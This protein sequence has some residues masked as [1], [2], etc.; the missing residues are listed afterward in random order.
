MRHCDEIAALFGPTPQCVESR[1]SLN[2]GRWVFRISQCQVPEVARLE[3]LLHPHINSDETKLSLSVDN[4]APL[5]L[6]TSQ[7]DS[8]KEFV[9]DL[10]P[11]VAA[12]QPESILELTV[13]VSKNEQERRLSIY[14]LNAFIE[15]FC[16]LT[17]TQWLASLEQLCSANEGFILFLQQKSNK[18]FQTETLVFSAQKQPLPSLA[19]SDLLSSRKDT[20]HFDGAAMCFVPEDFHLLTRSSSAELNQVLDR[21]CLITT[22]AFL[23]DV[24]TFS[25]DGTLTFKLNGYRAITGTINASPVSP[26]LLAELYRVYKWAYAG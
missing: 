2:E 7:L 5:L 14:D 21:L 17:D 18:A 19:R 10:Q 22:L 4:S 3:N 25:N 12:C 11:Y 26:E 9:A 1:E 16:R 13:S 8:I 24:S 15:C 20:C 23:C 6:T